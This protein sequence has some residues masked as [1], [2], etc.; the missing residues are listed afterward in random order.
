MLNRILRRTRRLTAAALAA[1]NLPRP[2]HRP[3]ALVPSD[4]EYLKNHL[5]WYI[6]RGM[7]KAGIPAVSIALVD[8]QQLIWAEGFGYADRERRVPATSETV[9][10]IGSITK[11]VNALAVMQLV[12][13]GRMDLDRP[14]TEYLPEFSMHTRW[15]QAAPIT[16]R[17]LLCHHAGLPTYLLKGFFSDQSLTELLHALRDE[18]LAYEPHT[19]FN[20]SNLGSN[21][22]GLAIERITGL[23]YA[24]AIQHQLL[25]PLGMQHT[26]VAPDRARLAR[27]YV[28]DMPVNPTPVRDVPAGGLCSNVLDLARFMRAV[29]A[30]GTLDNKHALS[31]SAIH[32]TF[33]PQYA[34]LPLDFGQ[35][36]GLGWMLS[37]LNIDGGGQQAW[38]NGGTKAYV[39]QL[40]L[41]PET[42][43]GV[44]VLANADNAGDLVYS[45]A[46][47]ALQ[48]ALEIRRGIAPPRKTFEPEV[49]LARDALLEHVGDYSLMGSL[50]HISLG[51][52]RLKLHVLKHVL[53]LV[54]LTRERF[55]VEF[56]LLGL[57]SVPIPFPP[58][59]FAQV[60]GRSFVLL[61][62]RVVVPAEQTPHYSIPETWQRCTGHYRILNPDEEYLV[63]LDHCRTLVENGKLLMDV[64]I[65]GIENRHVKV[66]MVPISDSEAYVFGLG[67]N[68]GDIVRILPDGDQQRIRY[69]GFVFERH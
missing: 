34:D 4:L 33:E 24:E 60:G 36:F 55:R 54:P 14:L 11:V 51:K 47:E 31:E 59:E 23:P 10:Q 35:R 21:L 1:A 62:D 65:S 28:H 45:S 8:D 27:G 58:V 32:A 29:L 44:V 41:L 57:K 2:P 48:L 3:P 20:Y 38:H 66:V 40:A 12:E 68:V 64:R 17:A 61:R 50:A 19:V 67:R 56:N 37:G 53:D 49:V 16:P 43:L 22:L 69:S 63:D 9:Y 39:S 52:K 15:P 46:E 26:G 30:G 13:Q 7:R 18:H 6:Q 42:K 25:T 5:H